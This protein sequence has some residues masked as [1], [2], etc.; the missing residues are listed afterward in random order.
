MSVDA[1]ELT[2]EQLREQT[3]A[4]LHENLPAGWIDETRQVI[5]GEGRLAFFDTTLSASQEEAKTALTHLGMDAVQR[6]SV[7]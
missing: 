3:R 4:W 2:G 1:P 5:E 7:D 6:L